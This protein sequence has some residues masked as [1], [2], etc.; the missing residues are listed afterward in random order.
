M[1]LMLGAIYAGWGLYG[2]GYKSGQDDLYEERRALDEAN[3]T[4]SIVNA[5]VVDAYLKSNGYTDRD[6]VC[7][8]IFE[9]VQ[10]QARQELN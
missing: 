1:V 4:A 2:W 10:D 9:L 6:G 5:A 7:E 3:E 8:A